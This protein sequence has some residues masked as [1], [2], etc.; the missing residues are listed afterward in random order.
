MATAKFNFPYDGTLY[1]KGDDLPDEV[2]RALPAVAV[3][4]H[5]EPLKAPVDAANGD[6]ED[7]PGDEDTVAYEDL[8]NDELRQELES[9]GLSTKGNKEILIARLEGDDADDA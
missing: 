8:T 5:V 1:K 6:D 4:G 7:T 2:A 9:R 3:S